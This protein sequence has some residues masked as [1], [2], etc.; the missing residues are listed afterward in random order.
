[1]IRRSAFAAVFALASC[2]LYATTYTLEANHTEGTIRWNHL[3]FS[4][5]TAQFSRV[6]GTLEFDQADPR[7]SSVMVTIPLA[8]L[9]S[10]VPDLDEDLRS[11]SFFDLAKYPT[12]TFK[13]TRVETTAMPN[14]LKVTGDLSLRGVVRPVTLDVTINKVGTNPRL[15]LPA[16]GFDATTA[17]KRS[18]FGL[19]KFVPQVSDEITI[20]ITCQADEAK[21]YAAY[22]KADAEEAAA[23]AAKAARK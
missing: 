19:G 23:E 4:Y 3:D 6:E 9:S 17:I 5:P 12:A 1:M 16:V 21:G 2:S 18:D 22:M 20:H 7:K 14:R 15:H 11:A 10:G 8:N 13:S